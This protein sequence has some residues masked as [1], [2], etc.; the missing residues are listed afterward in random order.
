MN[1]SP[2]QID[3]TYNVAANKYFAVWRRMWTVGDGDIMGARINP[4]SGDIVS[5]PG[6]IA[7]NT[8]VNDQKEPRITTNQQHRYLVVWSQ[9]YDPAHCCDWDIHVQELDVGGGLAGSS[10]GVAMTYNDEESPIAIARPGATRD[11]MVAWQRAAAGGQ[12]VEALR[13]GDSSYTVLLDVASASFWNNVHPVLAVGG[14]FLIAYESDSL[15]DPTVKSHIF[16]RLYWPHTT[17]LPVIV[18]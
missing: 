7:I 6:I 1:Q 9:V 16:A 15:G 3:V 8:A 5:P 13:W 12:R 11:Y 17:Y 14:P 10:Y 4:V 18:K 2:H